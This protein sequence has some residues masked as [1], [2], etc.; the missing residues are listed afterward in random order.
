M[1][2]CFILFLNSLTFD[3]KVYYYQ[4]NSVF[5]STK[6]LKI[7]NKI[8][9]FILMSNQTTFDTVNHSVLIQKFKFPEIK[10]PFFSRITD[11]LKELYQQVKVNYVSFRPIS[12]T[13]RVSISYNSSLLHLLM[14]F[15]FQSNSRVLGVICRYNFD[16]SYYMNLKSWSMN[17]QYETLIT[18]IVFIIL[19]K[20]SIS[21][22]VTR[23]FDLTLH[24][25]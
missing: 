12:V 14:T 25:I 11:Q 20:C 8:I 10:E 18:I 1:S 5:K 2:L 13:S 22:Y 15:N 17:R 24:T 21:F 16:T 3:P 6:L 19:K 7:P 4:F 9:R 23:S